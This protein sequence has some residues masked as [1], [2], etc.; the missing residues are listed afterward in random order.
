MKRRRFKQPAPLNQRLME[1]AKRLRKEAQGSPPGIERERLI[2]QAWQ[3]ER[4]VHFQEW[5]MSPGLQAPK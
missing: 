4:A 5:L 3:A 1:Q 2:Q